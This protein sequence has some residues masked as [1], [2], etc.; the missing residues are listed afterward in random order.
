MLTDADFPP[1]WS[2][3]N[4]NV[5]DEYREGAYDSC[6]KSYYVYDGSA[7]QVI[8]VYQNE[9]QAT[10]GYLGF[11]DWL[12]WEEVTRTLTAPVYISPF[13]DR[14]YLACAI[15][16]DTPMCRVIAKYGSYVVLFNTHYDPK[17]MT[18]I[19]LENILRSID[20]KMSEKINP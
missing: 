18:S 10:K 17:F 19:D 1:G 8:A 15:D 6:L 4:P 11:Y 5:D 20:N 14:Y 3:G 12:A 9:E 7:G 16:I 2:S 13:A